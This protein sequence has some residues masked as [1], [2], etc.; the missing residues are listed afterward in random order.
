MVTSRRLTA[1]TILCA[2]FLPVLALSDPGE[3]AGRKQPSEKISI[4]FGQLLKLAVTSPD[5]ALPKFLAQYRGH[6][7][8]A[9]KAEGFARDLRFVLPAKL[10]GGLRIDSAYGLHFGKSRGVV[11][12]YTRD[13]SMV[14][15]ILYPPTDDERFSWYA[16]F[17]CAIG[18]ELGHVA[19]NGKWYLARLS[20]ETTSRCVF[21]KLDVTLD[22]PPIMKAIAKP[23]PVEK[24]EK[25]DGA[26]T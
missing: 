2:G 8:D 14:L 19:R 12:K 18:T 10:P 20:D 5:E 25:P 17:P 1:C 7:I 6:K 21:G 22:I 9:S 13:A 11:A 23:K 4:D 3:I 24:K 16:S 26:M 15:I